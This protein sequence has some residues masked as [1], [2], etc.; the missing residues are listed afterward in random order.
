MHI[1]FRNKQIEKVCT[2]ASVARKKYGD[3]MAQKIEQRLGEIDAADTVEMMIEFR[4][5]R[6]HA[7]TGDRQGQYAVDLVH[8]QRLVFTKEGDTIQVAMIE[9][10]VAY[11]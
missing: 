9:E 6:C 3:R 8:P 5:G 4:I 10:I 7:L 11:H 2:N 1:A